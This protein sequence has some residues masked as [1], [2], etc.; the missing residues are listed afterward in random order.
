MELIFIL[1]LISLAGFIILRSAKLFTI[2][3][4]LVLSIFAIEATGV[5][6]LPTVWSV[7]QMILGVFFIFKFTKAIDQ[8]YQ[9]VLEKT[10]QVPSDLT[11]GGFQW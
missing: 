6:V 5:T 2:Q 10:H 8:N 3:L 9:L 11:T 7:I 4:L 1:G